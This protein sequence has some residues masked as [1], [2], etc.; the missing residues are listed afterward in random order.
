MTKMK[1]RCGRRRCGLKKVKKQALV[2]IREPLR[3][4][5]GCGRLAKEGYK[6]VDIE[7]G[8]CTDYVV[9]LS[10]RP[11]PWPDESVKETYA[12][13]F[14]EHVPGKARAAFMEELWRVLE[15]GGTA[16]FIVPYWSSMRSVQ[17]P[18]HEW[19]PLCEASFLY[20]NQ[21]WC[22]LNGVAHSMA[23]DA[24]CNFD[25]VYGYSIQ[26]EFV[27][28]NEESRTFASGHYVNAVSDLIIK[29]TKIPLLPPVS[30]KSH[31]VLKPDGTIGNVV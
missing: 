19:P 24:K 27:S 11:W 31:R 21:P 23:G 2:K 13:H 10:K 6:G 26:P 15:M 9:D 22:R 5:L 3:L 29:L 25:F 12:S 4:N 14:L 30:E 28:K 17:D 8:P 18:T 16:E 7:K 20:F 1:T